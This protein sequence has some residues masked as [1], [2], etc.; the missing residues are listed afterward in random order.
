MSR[1]GKVQSD[2]HPPEVR[3]SSF[4]DNIR[5]PHP[6]WKSGTPLLEWEGVYS[7]PWER[8]SPEFNVL[9][10]WNNMGLQGN[11]TWNFLPTQV[12]RIE[13]CDNML[14][15]SIPLEVLRDELIGLT[16]SRNLF[17]SKLDLTSL[18]LNFAELTASYNLLEGAIDLSALPQTLRILFLRCNHFVGVVDFTHIS[19]SIRI[20]LRDN[21]I[22]VFPE[23]FVSNNVLYD[24]NTE[25][26][27][28]NM[29]GYAALVAV[30][31]LSFVVLERCIGAL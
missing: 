19:T 8:Y 6:S 1:L 30:V 12:Y 16:A 4:I 11:L 24:V 26:D 23:S 29:S 18:P 21:A 9:L 27:N 2:I 20:D 10:R 28:K 5:N 17:S 25:Y 13:V 7:A 14:Q 22:F 3:L 31:V 15:G